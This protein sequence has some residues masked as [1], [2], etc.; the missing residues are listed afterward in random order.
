LSDVFISYSH[1][2]RAK[3]EVLINRLLE[4]GIN[5]WWDEHLPPGETWDEQIE[6]A[7]DSAAIVLIVWSG[8]SIR[9]QEV[10]DEAY[11][12]R[13]RRKALPVRIEE[14]QPPYRFRRIQGIDLLRDPPDTSPRWDALI[15]A[16]KEQKPMM[17]SDGSA[18]SADQPA[19]APV[20]ERARGVLLPTSM[21]V[22]SGLIISGLAAALLGQ[23]LLGGQSMWPT[24]AGGLL[25]GAGLMYAAMTAL[26]PRGQ[27]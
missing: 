6:R 21:L 9:S 16:L 2:D 25:G 17:W 22:T 7:L 13:D 5:V 8:T 23:L 14:V 11:F 1:R 3:V 18:Y 4:N 12:A 24:L 27:G 10:M 19:K 20:P 15:K 26:A